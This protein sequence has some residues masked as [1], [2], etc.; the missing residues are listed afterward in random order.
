[1]TNRADRIDEVSLQRESSPGNEANARGSFPRPPAA[2]DRAPADSR[3]GRAGEEPN[4]YTLG[5]SILEYD[6]YCLA[7]RLGGDVVGRDS[8]NVPGP[9]HSCHDRSL[10]I[11]IDPNA[12]E[13]FVVYS[14][15]GD[16]F[17]LCRDYV[18]KQLGLLRN[19]HAVGRSTREGPSVPALLR[20][21]RIAIAMRFWEQ[22]V[23][24]I[25][26][27][28]D[29]YLREFR[30]LVL[31]EDVAGNVMRLHPSLKYD[32]STRLPAMVCLMRDI[33]TGE[34]CGVHRTFLDPQ[35]GAKVC[36]KMLG[37][38]K[39]AAIK[40]DDFQGP[41]TI[42]E[43]IETVLS[44]RAAGYGPAWAVG[45]S[46]GVKE[47]PLLA[48]VSV[49][50]VLAEDDEASKRAVDKCTGNY[51]RAGKPVT[52]VS[53][54]IGQDFNDTWKATG[55]RSALLAGALHILKI[56]SDLSAGDRR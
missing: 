55:G 36:R 41:L 24:P 46:S 50:T 8:V 11:K 22:S 4:L 28:A 32:D 18:R 27:I 9:G 5:P 49:L 19:A 13:G 10:S 31:P 42:G 51:L 3:G 26:S 45:S 17:L 23:S 43:G 54:L 48:R 40:F 15:A 2:D 38:A 35:T 12:P 16:D 21:R 37:V 7:E 30:G 33:V 25:N 29:Y 47:F 56:G 53:T 44:A 20:Q 1:M 52:V 39:G 6:P 14:H 34:P